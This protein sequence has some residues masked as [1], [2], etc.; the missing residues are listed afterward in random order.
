MAAVRQRGQRAQQ[1]QER[2]DEPRHVGHLLVGHQPR[3]L[4]EQQRRGEDLHG[5]HAR[6]EPAQVRR[7]QRE[8]VVLRRVDQPDRVQRVLAAL[9]A[10]VDACDKD[11]R[12]RLP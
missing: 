6:V 10:A 5:A 7:R 2:V 4:R 3:Q 8:A 11:G 12:R 1:Q 9:D